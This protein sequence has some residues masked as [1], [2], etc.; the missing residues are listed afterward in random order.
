VGE[1]AALEALGVELA[2]RKVR[3]LR[4]PVSLPPEPGA[5]GTWIAASLV[6][7]D[8]V[9]GELRRQIEALSRSHYLAI[10]LGELQRLEWFLGQVSHIPV[11]ENFAWVTGWTDDLDGRRLVAALRREGLDVML[12]F[13]KP[14]EK[15]TAP[16]V[17]RNP[18]WARPFEM[19]ARLLG[20]PA[21]AETDPSPV[22]ALLVPVLFGYM[23]GDVGQGL[24]L[25]AAGMALRRRWPLLRLLIPNGL[26]AMAFGWVF[27]SVFGQDGWVA[28]LWVNPVEQPLPVLAVPLVGGVIVLL[29]GVMLSALQALW[30]GELLRWV[31]AEAAV[32]VMYLALVV[33]A[34][35]PAG[36]YVASGAALWFIT[37]SLVKGSNGP[38][39]QRLAAAVGT[40]VETMLQLLLNTVSF[41]RVGAFA[42]AHAGL[43]VAFTAM[44]ATVDSAVFG[45][46]TLLIGNLIV[47]MLEGLV[48]S[49][50]TT[51]LILFE[52]FIRFLRGTGRTFR[53][54][55]A[56]GLATRRMT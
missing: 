21:G 25:V 28:P 14:P 43:S 49:I 36:G 24:V 23:F 45:L 48:V 47:I 2:E 6:Q 41:V 35:L 54:L 13:P 7:L 44:A 40:L 32:P 1:P 31:Q 27:G 11:S 42:L 19:F 51:R 52:F 17:L 46:A 12:H 18:W 5:A 8:Q 10:T 15:L 33:A 9:I 29:L 34:F 38:F 50:Q 56:P 20:T 3:V 37:G 55:T 39:L 26:S 30:R 4:L 53:P 22:L 16:L